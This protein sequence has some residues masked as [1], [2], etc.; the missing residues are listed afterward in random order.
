LYI[1]A[2]GNGIGGLAFSCVVKVYH[3]LGAK[4]FSIAAAGESSDN[5]DLK[6]GGEG[7]SGKIWLV[8]QLLAAIHVASAAEAMAFAAA[9]GMNGSKVV[10]IVLA[11]AGSSASFL[12][13]T[14]KFQAADFTPTSSETTID[15]YT[16]GLTKVLEESR[17]V[18]MPLFLGSAAHQTF[19]MAKAAGWGK[20]DGS[21]VVK[22]WETLMKISTAEKK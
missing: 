4:D 10:E 3:M 18:G 22:V 16:S 17:R 15:A 19:L 11:A 14:P 8:N 5:L 7:D 20:E 12:A 13:T 2:K 21:A 9:L 6:D 1:G